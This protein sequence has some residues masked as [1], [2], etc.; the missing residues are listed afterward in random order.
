MMVPCHRDATWEFEKRVIKHV[1]CL[2]TWFM[3][4]PCFLLL[5]GYRCSNSLASSGT[6]SSILHSDYSRK[7]FVWAEGHSYGCHGQWVDKSPSAWGEQLL[8]LNQQRRGHRRPQV[9]IFTLHFLCEKLENVSLF[10]AVW[11]V[12]LIVSLGL[13]NI[14]NIFCQK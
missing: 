7:C 5:S 2:V 9:K 3:L 11:K 1:L 14:G 4:R 8:G 12:C 13:A 6:S 10:F